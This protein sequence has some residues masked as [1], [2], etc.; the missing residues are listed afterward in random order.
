MDYYKILGVDKSAT[1]DE[2]KKAYRKQAKQYH[3]DRNPDN[4]EAE[5][6]FKQ[7]AE[8]WEILGDDEKR[9]RYNRLGIDGMKHGGMHETDMG[10]FFNHMFGG[11]GGFRNHREKP[12]VGQDLKISFNLTLE[13]IFNGLKK[14]IKYNR[15][16]EC[17]SCN[18]AGGSGIKTCTMCTGSG[19]VMQTYQG[20]GNTVIQQ[21]NSCHVCKGTGKTIDNICHIC[22]GSGVIQKEVEIEIEIPKSISHNSSSAYNGMGNSIR[23]GK[24]GRLIVTV[25]QK[26]HQ[27]YERDN[28][29]LY[30]RV[31]IP[32]QTFIL[33]GSITVPTIEDT[34]IKAKIPEY[35]KLGDQLSIKGKGMYERD[36]DKRG[37][38]II[39]LDLNMPSEVSDE[40][41]E[42]LKK[43]DNQLDKTEN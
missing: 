29:T 25:L 28:N 39:I 36:S 7:A 15:H 24:P 11:F 17:D 5:T 33:G 8:A 19:M 23:N 1:K 22:T 32:Y 27:L 16:E 21:V 6:K 9:D 41:K 14:K 26:K 43:L 30:I 31:K 2:I 42:I 18:G 20:P 34:K 40:E 13:E 10:D 38:M 12:I 35:S 4:P 3:P 37:D